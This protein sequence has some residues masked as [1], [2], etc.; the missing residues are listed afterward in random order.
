MA[1]FTNI[2]HDLMFDPKVL[3]IVVKYDTLLISKE[4]VLFSICIRAVY[5]KHKA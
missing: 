3:L 5:S 1:Y 4:L 2:D